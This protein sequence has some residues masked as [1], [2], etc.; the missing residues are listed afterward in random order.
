MI[1]RDRLIPEDKSIFAESTVSVFFPAHNF[2]NERTKTIVSDDYGKATS[3]F[4]F[5]NVKTRENPSAEGYTDF[6]GLLYYY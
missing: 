1:K 2:S 5:S 3:F 6:A 4:L